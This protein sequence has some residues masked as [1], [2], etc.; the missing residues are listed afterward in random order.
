MLV[1]NPFAS[2][3]TASVTVTGT[4]GSITQSLTFTLYVSA[5]VGSTGTGTPVD[6][7]SQ[8]NVGGIYTDG[9][10]YST[11]GLDGVGYSY[12]ANVLTPS[13]VF[14]GVLF[15]FGP[16][17]EPDAVGCNG[18]SV[19]L[20]QGQFSSLLLLATGVEG[21]QRSETLTVNYTDG[22][23]SQFVRSF[24]DW[25]TPQQLPGEFEA[26]IMPYRNYENGTK[27]RRMFNLYGYKLVLNS[28][29]IVQSISLPNDPDVLLLAA[30]LLPVNAASVRSH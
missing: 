11:G 28:A 29:K 27:D 13:R 22:T 20:P 8:F 23:S 26:V 9:A 24:S 14:D 17:N 30:T 6:L 15:E 12:S 1:G 3:G 7:S 16:A 18:Q 19:A 2:T 21:D 10:T 5:G 4:S 25:F